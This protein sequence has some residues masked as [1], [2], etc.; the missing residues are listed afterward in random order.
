MDQMI[1]ELIQIDHQG[2]AAVKEAEAKRQ[3]IMAHASVHKKE[4]YA[5]FAH[6]YAQRLANKKQEL[7]ESIAQKKQ[8]EDDAYALKLQKLTDLYTRQKETWVKELV[9]RVLT[10]Q[11]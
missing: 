9:A 7:Q 6:V 3:E 4:T 10:G 8:Q 5:Q 11:E 2:T 1:K